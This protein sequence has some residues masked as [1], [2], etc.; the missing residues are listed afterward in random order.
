M[1]LLNIDSHIQAVRMASLK[2]LE[3]LFD[4]LGCNLDESLVS[5]LIA[6]IKTYPSMTRR[7]STFQQSAVI[8]FFED[9]WQVSN[10][11]YEHKFDTNKRDFASEISL[12]ACQDRFKADLLG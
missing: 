10:D 3:F 1:L 12:R 2:T 11:T 6:V 8:S 9:F 7:N 4:T 5:I